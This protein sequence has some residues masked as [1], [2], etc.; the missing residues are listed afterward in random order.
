MRVSLRRQLLF[1][2]SEPG[3]RKNRRRFASQSSPSRYPSLHRVGVRRFEPPCLRSRSRGVV[4]SGGA[5][6]ARPLRADWRLS[7]LHLALNGAVTP[8]T[9]SGAAYHRGLFTE[10]V[11]ARLARVLELRGLLADTRHKILSLPPDC[12]LPNARAQ[13]LL[14]SRA[15]MGGDFPE[16]CGRV[17][18]QSRRDCR[19]RDGVLMRFPTA[20]AGPVIGVSNIVVS[21]FPL[22]LAVQAPAVVLA[23]FTA[24]ARGVVGECAG[25][26][27]GR[28]VWVRTRRAR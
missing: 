24:T 19:N 9:R 21:G 16:Q 3:W 14:A 13:V 22:A 6:W 28:A 7:G 5:H 26:S 20:G 2:P 27:G 12:V 18:S 4:N 10:W 11:S 15:D 1:G 25:C 23:A 17:G 8:L